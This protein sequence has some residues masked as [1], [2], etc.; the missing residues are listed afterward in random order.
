M[1]TPLCV[2]RAAGGRGKYGKQNRNQIQW[3]G[4]VSIY[5]AGPAYSCGFDRPV[6]SGRS[7]YYG[8]YYC[9]RKRFIGITAQ[10]KQIQSD[11]EARLKQREIVQ[12]VG[13]T[14]VLTQSLI[15]RLINRVYVFPGDRIEIEY[16]TQDF[17]GTE[18]SGKEA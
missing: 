7:W 17:L 15:D 8:E 5:R 10:T 1:A 3:A 14:D 11:Y 13:S 4:P 9:W 12:E 6:I 16:V 18:K 2:D